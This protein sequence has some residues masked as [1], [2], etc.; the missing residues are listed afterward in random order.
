KPRILLSLSDLFNANIAL[1]RI[2]LYTRKDQ[3][4]R[5]R[6]G[7]TQR[8]RKSRAMDGAEQKYP[9]ETRLS[10]GSAPNQA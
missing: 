3:S 2:G 9:K 6:F 8:A 1:R 4:V 10:P 7:C 5:N